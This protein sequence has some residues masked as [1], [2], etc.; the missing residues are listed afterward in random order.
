MKNDTSRTAEVLLPVGLLLWA[1]LSLG[2]NL[3]AAPAKFQVDTLTLVD[4]LSI[5]RA[6]FAWLGIAEGLFAVSILGLCLMFKQRPGLALIAALVLLA[7]QQAGLHPMLQARTDL[8]LSG[9]PAPSSGLHLV[10]IAAEIAKFVLL[11][12]AAL[13]ALWYSPIAMQVTKGRCA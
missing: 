3:I 1:G 5:G 12:I 8:I 13:N 4:L 7:I 9:Q 2:G 6:Q 11:V 10:F